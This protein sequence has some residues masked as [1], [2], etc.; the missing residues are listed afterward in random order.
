MFWKNILLAFTFFLVT[1]LTLVICLFSIFA[2][3]K[4]NPAETVYFNNYLSKGSSIPTG[5]RVYASLPASFPS[6]SEA[7]TSAD[8]RAEIVKQYL[9]KYN[10]PLLPFADLIV[11]EADKYRVDFRLTTAIAQQE[12]NLCKAIPSESYN[13]WG[14]GIH[15]KGTLGFSSFEEGI[16]TVTE[17]ISTD[18]IAQGFDTVEKIMTRYTPLSNGSW[19]EGVNKFINEME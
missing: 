2:L 1:P 17:G 16:K 10:S 4:T 7:I 19:A 15:S 14:W 12:S 11:A 9:T 3:H 13:C 8:A 18:Y 6:I 5:S